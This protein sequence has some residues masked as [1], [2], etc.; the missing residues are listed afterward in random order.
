[1]R[2]S[3]ALILLSIMIWY[4]CLA[5]S[6]VKPFFL[7]SLRRAAIFLAGLLDF[8]PFLPLMA[9]SWLENDGSGRRFCGFAIM[10]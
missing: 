2:M 3:R 5:V 8:P 10:F 9:C 4:S 1:M 6:S 7:R